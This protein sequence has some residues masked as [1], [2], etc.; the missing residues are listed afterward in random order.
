M[1]RYKCEFESILS[2]KTQH[3]YIARSPANLLK[4]GYSPE[5]EFNLKCVCTNR[6]SWLLF[7]RE[8]RQ[9]DLKLNQWTILMKSDA[10]YFNRIAYRFITK[11]LCDRAW[12]FAELVPHVFFAFLSFWAA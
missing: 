10:V 7:L 4:A 2:F 8:R 1:V 11:D 5:I 12:V 3:S 6:P 9:F